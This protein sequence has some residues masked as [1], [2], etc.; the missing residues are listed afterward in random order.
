[1]GAKLTSLT[2]GD[3]HRLRVLENRVLRKMFGPKRCEVTGQWRNYIM[4]S[5]IIC[6]P[7]QMLCGYIKSGRIR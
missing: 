6:T 3:K 2:L 7:H 4:K 1:M 5:F